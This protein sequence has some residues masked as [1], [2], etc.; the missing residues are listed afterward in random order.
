MRTSGQSTETPLPA[1]ESG[2]RIPV[3]LGTTPDV[4]GNVAPPAVIVSLAIFCELLTLY[5][6]V[7]PVPVPN[8]EIVVPAVTPSPWTMA[9]TT[10]A[11]TMEVTFRMVPAPPEPLEMVAVKIDPRWRMVTPAPAPRSVTLLADINSGLLVPGSWFRM[12]VPELS[13]TIWFA[14]AALIAFWMLAVSSRPTPRGDNPPGLEIVRPALTA[15]MPAPDWPPFDIRP[16]FC[17]L[18][19]ASLSAGMNPEPPPMGFLVSGPD[20]KV[21]RTSRHAQRRVKR[22]VAWIGAG[23]GRKCRRH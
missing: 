12:N 6:P 5:V 11:P 17:Q 19:M 4:L 1:I 14:L 7:P 3:V 23:G 16:A 8:D 15:R 10:S 18:S 9:P 22:P 21:T 20:A 2:M 13:R